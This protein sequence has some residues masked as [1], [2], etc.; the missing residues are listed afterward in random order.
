VNYV[1]P[2]YGDGNNQLVDFETLHFRD[3]AMLTS[4]VPVI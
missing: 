4:D 1:G 2:W 3:Q